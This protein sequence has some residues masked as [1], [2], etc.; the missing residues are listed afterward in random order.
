MSLLLAT[1]DLAQPGSQR[2]PLADTEVANDLHARTDPGRMTCLDLYRL[3]SHPAADDP[4]S[5]SAAPAPTRQV[6]DSMNHFQLSSWTDTLGRTALPRGLFLMTL[7]FA[8]NLS[9]G[10]L[11]N[12]NRQPL[13]T[14]NEPV[15]MDM[16]C[17]TPSQETGRRYQP[18]SLPGQTE[19][20]PMMMPAPLLRNTPRSTVPDVATQTDPATLASIHTLPKIEASA[21]TPKWTSPPR[22][23]RYLFLTNRPPVGHQAQQAILSGDRV[24]AKRH[25]EQL[26]RLEPDHPTALAG[27]A[28]LA[29]RDQQWEQARLFYKTLLGRDPHSPLALAGLTALDPQSDLQRL[30]ERLR[31]PGN[32]APLVW[33]LHFVRGTRLA[34]R[35]DWGQA[36]EA[37]QAALQQ[38]PGN[39]DLHHNLAVSLDHSGAK[40]AALEQ[41]RLALR[42]LTQRGW[43]GFDPQRIQQRIATL[44]AAHPDA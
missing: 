42:S 7:L 16:A 26:L 17:S 36:K 1:L 39:P 38:D 4:S 31:Q 19:K 12:P 24:L 35:N 21:T 29:V 20:R 30:E 13:T 27:L 44:E 14:A 33:P 32:I 2:L 18:L 3:S 22:P 10:P 40:T 6:P 34:A 37:F 25:Y 41:Y 8:T 43:A 28:A 9:D 11:P 23:A 15:T 5:S